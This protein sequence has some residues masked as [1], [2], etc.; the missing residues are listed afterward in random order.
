MKQHKIFIK[1]YKAKKGKTKNHNILYK[2]H[3]V[4][5]YEV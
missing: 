1:L 3:E 2:S 4:K 5:R